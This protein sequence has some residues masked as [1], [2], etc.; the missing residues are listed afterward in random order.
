[1][2]ARGYGG[3]GGDRAPRRC[4]RRP[5]RAPSLG[6]EGRADRV[7]GDA[8][9]RARAHRDARG[10]RELPERDLRPCRA[11]WRVDPAARRG[12]RAPVSRGASGG[13]GGDG[14]K[15]TL[16]GKTVY[17][18]PDD[19]LA[20]QAYDHGATLP[21]LTLSIGA[22]V[23]MIE[24]ILAEQFAT[25]VPEVRA[26]AT[27]RRV[28]M[29][30]TMVTAPPSASAR[31]NAVIT[32]DAVT[33]AIVREASLDA[34]RFLARGVTEDGHFRY[35]VDAPTNR[36]LGGYDWPRHS[37]ATYFL[38]QAYGLGHDPELRAAA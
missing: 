16:G 17:V 11:R 22:D 19:L 33:P 9:H 32:P 23:P 29:E 5:P 15:A 2:V 26:R 35:I 28:Q 27:I 37:G 25:T 31:T 12:A 4:G 24:A 38:A 3:D 10:D 13:A 1:M 20:R 21:S 7:D 34:A 30:R 6:G 14:V 36:T 8:R 18:T